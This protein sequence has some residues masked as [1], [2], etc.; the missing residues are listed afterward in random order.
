MAL[1]FSSFL[2]LLYQNTKRYL[3]VVNRHQF[4][5]AH[6]ST[7]KGVSRLFCSWHHFKFV[8]QDSYHRV[9]VYQML[10]AF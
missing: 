3:F 5:H 8:P 9:D 10:P 6:Y 2:T 7:K 4:F 1:Q